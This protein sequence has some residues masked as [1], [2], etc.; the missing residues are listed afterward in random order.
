MILACSYY[1]QQEHVGI[2][3]I[4]DDIALHN[5]RKLHCRA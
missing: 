5:A 2:S 1:M 3:Y 4:N